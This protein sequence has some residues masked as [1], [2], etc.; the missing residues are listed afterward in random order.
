MDAWHMHTNESVFPDSFAYKPE[1]WLDNPRGPDEKKY[2]TRYNISF[3]RGTR[4][5][6]GMHIANAELY[7]AFATIFRRFQ[8]SLFETDSSCVD[9]YKDLLGPIAVP[10]NPGVRVLVNGYQ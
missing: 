7:I 9:V 2:L 10:G 5:C 6:L 1:R 8:F 3:G 4:M